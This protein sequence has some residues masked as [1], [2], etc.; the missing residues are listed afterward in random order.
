VITHDE[1]FVQ[2]IGRSENCSH[3]YRISK[4]FDNP[5]DPPVSKIERHSIDRFG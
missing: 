4:E 2:L 5:G 3:Y 1:D